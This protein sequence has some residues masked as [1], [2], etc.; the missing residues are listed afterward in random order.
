M[1]KISRNTLHILYSNKLILNN[2]T[3]VLMFLYLKCNQ[4]IFTNLSLNYIKSIMNY[5]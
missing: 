2:Y 5:E 4:L 1:I 3:L